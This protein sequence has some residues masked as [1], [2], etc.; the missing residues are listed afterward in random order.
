MDLRRLL[1]ILDWYGGESPPTD[2][3]QLL[4]TLFIYA[5]PIVIIIIIIIS[6]KKRK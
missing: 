1:Q 6:I 2:V 4:L 5:L 3:V